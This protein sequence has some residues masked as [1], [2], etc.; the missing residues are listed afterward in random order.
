[1]LRGRAWSPTSGAV[2]F[3]GT[4]PTNGKSVTIETPD[5]Y[6]V[7]LT[8]LGA[9]LVGKGASVAEGDAVATIGPSGTPEV[10]GPYVHLGI[11][12]TADPNGYLDPLTF[13]PP[14]AES[15]PAQSAPPV[16][17]PAA[18]SAA[19]QQPASAPATAH[20]SAVPKS[21]K[22]PSR[23]ESRP[24]RPEHRPAVHAAVR[25]PGHSS[26]VQ[27]RL[28]EEPEGTSR[29]P[30]LEVAARTIRVA[31]GAGH[32]VRPS[33]RAPHAQR[34]PAPAS[35]VPLALA[36]N[37]A[38]ALVALLA[39]AAA[40]RRRRRAPETGAQVLHLPRPQPARRAA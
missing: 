9:I 36:S 8:H 17:Q 25:V 34:P 35:S 37:G 27:R 2:S 23:V 1:M 24:R 22:R 5:G 16:S 26:R 28:R 14:P 6:S 29:R 38:A 18:T 10:D 21:G 12:L 39:A 32:E 31:L 4:L 15:E 19:P 30:V 11:R 20:V 33:V 40:G 3:A 7:T 13:L